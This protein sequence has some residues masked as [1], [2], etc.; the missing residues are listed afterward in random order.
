MSPAAPPF[1]SL[2]GPL[3]DQALGK[4]LETCDWGP[5]GSLWGSHSAPALGEQSEGLG[6]GEGT[7]KA[8]EG[9]GLGNR[10]SVSRS[11][12]SDSL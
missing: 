3:S 8:Q 1:S 9:G 5:T 4:L 7:C 6:L 12:V 11:G 2:P 10:E